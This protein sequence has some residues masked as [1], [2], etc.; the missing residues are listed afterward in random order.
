MPSINVEVQLSS[1]QL[2]KAVEQL[3]Q[4]NLEQFLSQIVV[5]YTHKAAAS[6]VENE[7]QL[8]VQS[9]QHMI[10]DNNEKLI[11]KTEVESLTKEEYK[12]LLYLGEQIDRLQAQRIEYMA[13]LAKIHGISL[14]KLMENLGLE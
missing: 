10:I 5:L 4:P 13:E 12:A 6:L 8:F 9:H 2:F 3:T 14:T 7:S 11:D 1:E